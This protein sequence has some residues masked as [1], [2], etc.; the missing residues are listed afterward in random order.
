[1]GQFSHLP[2]RRGVGI[3]LFNTEGKVF[4]AKRL[5]MI[6]DAW[7]MPQGGIDDDEPPRAAALR[8][9]QE[10]TGI[11]AESVSFLAEYPGWL[12]YDLPD[13]LQPLIWKG[14]FRG[15]TQKWFALRLNGGDALI[16]I[17][18]Y[19]TPEFSEWK[20]VDIHALPDLIVP[21]KRALYAKLVAEFVDCAN[22]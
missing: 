4:A 22:G 16:N 17:N 6:S 21:F 8:E 19:E 13:D 11:P 1:M 9:L 7:Q 2:F 20:W 10:E 5:D 3:M 12:D 18:A 14:K 15:Q